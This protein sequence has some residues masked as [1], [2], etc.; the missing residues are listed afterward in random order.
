MLSPISREIRRLEHLPKVISEKAG[1]DLPVRPRKR[2][3]Y[4][5]ES[6]AQLGDAPLVIDPSGIYFRP[7]GPNFLTIG[8]PRHLDASPRQ[9][10]EDYCLQSA[11]CSSLAERPRR[12]PQ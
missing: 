6:P 7:E 10:A 9:A 8:P 5:V 4:H 3:V 1:V 11:V 12:R 2:N